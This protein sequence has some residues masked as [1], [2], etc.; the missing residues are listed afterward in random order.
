MQVQP[1]SKICEYDHEAYTKSH[2]PGMYLQNE[3]WPAIYMQVQ[4]PGQIMFRF[5][6]Q[7]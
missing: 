3:Q 6:L 5:L 1:A 2:F 7:N 4:Y